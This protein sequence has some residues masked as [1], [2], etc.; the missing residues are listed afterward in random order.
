[1]DEFLGGSWG[2]LFEDEGLD[3]EV[4][5]PM[6]SE[7]DGSEG[8]SS[9]DGSGGGGGGD[10]ETSGDHD[11]EATG[12][13]EITGH[14]LLEGKG[15]VAVLPPPQYIDLIAEREPILV[16][17]NLL[18]NDPIN[19]V[20]RG[21]V[22]EERN[23]SPSDPLDEKVKG[24]QGLRV[25]VAPG[26]VARLR[27]LLESQGLSEEDIEIVRLPGPDQNQA[28]A[29]SLVDVLYAHTPYMETVLVEQGAVLLIDQSGGEVPELANRQIH[30]LVTTQSFADAQP[31]LLV[32]MIRAIHHAQQLIH[33]DLD[34]TA[35]SLFSSGVDG[36]EQP[37]LDTLLPIYE[38]AIP[39]IPGV[40]IE[41][42]EIAHRLFPASHTA[43][44]LSGIDLGDFVAPQFS[45][46]AV[47][48]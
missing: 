45:K 20:I 46:Q 32:A 36:L 29:D 17:A 31:Q 34:G 30:S 28:F 5:V 11:H 43:P 15:E 2:R 39:E 26:P 6:S 21:S 8:G 10:S 37:L 18:Q 27:V 25:G 13:S 12:G 22:L 14:F 4:I 33:T 9:G 48:R 40:T 3:V 47:G 16:V 1:M 44:D 41:G 35:R 7:G 38:P 19:V 23:L 24:L 42:I